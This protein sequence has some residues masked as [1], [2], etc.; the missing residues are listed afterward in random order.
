VDLCDTKLN[1]V[2]VE[3]TSASCPP[4]LDTLTGRQREVL[5]LIVQGR[6]NKE[7]ARTLKLRPGT[8]K[9]HISALFGKLGIRR[10]AALAVMGERLSAEAVERSE[11]H[12][13]PR[14][15]CPSSARITWDKV[16]DFLFSLPESEWHRVGR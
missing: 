12:L 7:I 6:S 13:R 4:T 14:V 11:S 2:T 16:A 1:L 10:R 5:N 8:V 9:V 3:A 15:E